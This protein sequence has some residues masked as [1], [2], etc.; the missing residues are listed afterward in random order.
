MFK[1]C[2]NL[3]NYKKDKYSAIG[4]DGIIE[5]ISDTMG[6]QNGFFVEFGAWD[7]IYT[8]NCR[9]LF[10]N[11][12]DGIFIEC[13]KNKY[14]ELKSNYKKHKNIVCLHKK[15]NYKGK[16]IFDNVVDEYVPDSGIDFC[17]ID[18]DGLDVEIF[19]TINKY[20]PKFVCIESGFML[21]PY[22][23]RV[24]KDVAKNAIQQS[25]SV[26]VDVFK[27]KNY[28]IV[29]A[30]YNCFF[31]KEEYYHLFNVPTDLLTLYFNGLRAFIKYI[32][33]IW[34]KLKKIDGFN[35]YRNQIALD[36]LNSTN[37]DVTKDSIHRR[38]VWANKKEENII[39]VI[40]TIENR[41]KN[42]R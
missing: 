9:K 17:S 42:K 28:R 25:L 37:Y 18:V 20:Q 29:C 1:N 13:D 31:V 24:K 6:I 33:A 4:N 32:P 34:R 11:G 30:G 23:G 22:H 5:F 27:K 26:T 19:E 39:K 38:K 14:K 7:G 12:W 10:E 15:I 16:N 2:T 3:L 36:I 35:K 8:N 21:S 41:E 40:D